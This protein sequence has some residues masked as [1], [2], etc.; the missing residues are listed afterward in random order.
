MKVQKNSKIWVGA[1]L[2]LAML[3]VSAC[4]VKTEKGKDGE[5]KKVAISTPAGELKVR[6]TDVDIRDTGLPLYPGAQEK[7][8]EKRSDDN[9]ANVNID[10]PFF[11][12]K[13]V[14]LTF[15][16]ND[17]PDKVLAWYRDQMKSMGSV[18]ECRGP[19]HKGK[20]NDD[21]DKPV[22]CDSDTKVNESDR[23]SNSVE[24][25]AGTNG[26]QHVVSVKPNGSGSEF[27]LVYVRVHK[28][29]KDSI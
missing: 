27:A 20:D 28:G 9:K 4:T 18:V 12:L 11:G 17:S 6:N 19:H 7:P 21:L 16:T 3:G 13:V 10:T 26:N 24:L 15:T 29:E 14:A 23:D 25:K 5:E 1:F 22:S 8:K 2:I